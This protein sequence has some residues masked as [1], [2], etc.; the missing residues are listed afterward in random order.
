MKHSRLLEPAI[1]AA[2]LLTHVPGLAEGIRQSSE[3]GK[4][5]VYFSPGMPGQPCKECPD[6]RLS[7]Y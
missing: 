4:T 1:V 3:S 2:L 7:S 5:P 6:E